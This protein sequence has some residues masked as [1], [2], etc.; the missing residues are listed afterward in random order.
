M[1]TSLRP[2]FH[3]PK[4]LEDLH[5]SENG[6]YCAECEKP[7]LDLMGKDKPEIV[8]ILKQYETMPCVV[9]PKH[10]LDVPV[11]TSTRT[12]WSPFKK[13]AAVIA[14]LLFA[15][16]VKALFAQTSA[17]KDDKRNGHEKPVGHKAVTVTGKINDQY[18]A[19]VRYANVGFTLGGQK[20]FTVQTNWD[21]AYSA[22]LEYSPGISEM[23]ISIECYGYTAQ[24]L[25]NLPVQ[26]AAYVFDATLHKMA[27]DEFIVNVQEAWLGGL[28]MYITGPVVTFQNQGNLDIFGH[29]LPPALGQ[30]PDYFEILDYRAEVTDEL[31]QHIPNAKIELKFP[32][33]EPRIMYT[34]GYGFLNAYI[35]LGREVLHA[36][37]EVSAPGFATKKVLFFEFDEKDRIVYRLKTKPQPVTETPAAAEETTPLPQ[38]T[39]VTKTEEPDNAGVRETV[40]EHVLLFPNPA[41]ETATIR[42]AGNKSSVTIQLTDLSGKILLR[43]TIYNQADITLDVTPYAPGQYAVLVQYDG[44]SFT[45][46]LVISR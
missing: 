27:K 20:V 29:Y 4:K 23:E 12:F 31:G 8:D 13:S 16:N 40:A 43:K 7:V 6:L 24:N 10:V 45:E 35:D 3:C 17:Q 5:A 14:L 36:H 25:K 28:G 42:L 11:Y 26:K 44:K 19:P 32:G 30:E 37:I 34:D 22:T 33:C 18:G 1:E 38:E 2:H 21:G 39:P 15:G 41:G 46:K 9:L